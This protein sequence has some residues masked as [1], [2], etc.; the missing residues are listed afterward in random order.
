MAFTYRYDARKVKQEHGRPQFPE[1]LVEMLKR[2]LE[3][4]GRFVMTADGNSMLPA[5]RAG[6]QVIVEELKRRPEIG[7]I[8]LVCHPSGL[9]AH[10]VRYIQGDRLITMGDNN[11]LID[12]ACTIQDV[13]GII[14][15]KLNNG[16]PEAVPKPRV[17]QLVSYVRLSRP[18]KVT[19]I[20]PAKTERAQ[21]EAIGEQVGF[22][23]QFCSNHADFYALLGNDEY[24]IGLSQQAPVSEKDLLRIIETRAAKGILHF[25][26]GGKY[27]YPGN[28][29][30]LLPHDTVHA[31]V[32]IGPPDLSEQPALW[33]LGYLTGLVQGCLAT[34]QEN[35]VAFP[36]LGSSHS[37][38]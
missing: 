25:I 2:A 7:D 3:R 14:R 9:R 18:V 5:I 22:D 17:P 19:I 12:E 8:V 32:R 28:S 36:F 38:E 16:Q 34:K 23:I 10:R 1:H 6:E 24:R 20:G 37:Q 35:V 15:Y 27:G 21:F 13:L 26:I 4:T 29:L 31:L 30:G 11:K 33:T